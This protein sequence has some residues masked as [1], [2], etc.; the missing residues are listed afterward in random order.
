[1]AGRQL[2]LF[3]GAAALALGAGCAGGGEDDDGGDRGLET[4]D[5]TTATDG[6]EP[7]QTEESSGP[8]QTEATGEAPAPPEDAVAFADP[9]GT[10]R[11]GTDPTWVLRDPASA[12]TGVTFWTVGP[13][14]DG[15]DPNVNAF[16]Q[17]APVADLEA[18]LDLTE[19]QA[20]DSADITDV[21][22]L[23]RR[24]VAGPGGDLGVL[25]YSG[26][27]AGVALRFIGV[28]ALDG[29]RATLVTF[30][31]PPAAYAE[32]VDEVEPYLLTVEQT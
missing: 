16:T 26:T 29:D 7:G 3:I 2:A 11:L 31:A 32:L 1:M 15:F 27:V 22:F 13:T 6:G 5:A 10:F 8:G 28:A 21:Q 18:Y 14:T 25:E 20:Q 4:D 24:T 23:D 30:T 9:G 19:A 17:P 12:P